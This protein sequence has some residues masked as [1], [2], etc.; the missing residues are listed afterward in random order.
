MKMLKNLSRTVPFLI[1]TLLA[2]GGVELLYSL[3][4]YHFWSQEKN[5]EKNSLESERVVTRPDKL[6]KYTNYKAIVERNIFQSYVQKNSADLE[7][8]Q[9]PL[10]ELEATTLDLVLM[11]TI[12]A[13]ND[14]SRAIILEKKTNKQELFYEGDSIQDA[15][16]KKILRGKVILHYQGNDEVLDMSEAS[17]LTVQNAAAPSV[18]AREEEGS[19]TVRQPTP[20]RPKRRV[21]PS[22]FPQSENVPADLFPREIP[23]EEP[24]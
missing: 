3:A 18:K 19:Q 4:E 15:Q 21:T 5:E 16:I 23:E 8:Q 12:I 13:E 2:I 14:T 24:Q 20:L 17:R 10:D 11:G 1:V 6:Q 7:K 22:D 9:K